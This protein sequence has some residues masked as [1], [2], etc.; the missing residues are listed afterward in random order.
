[1][2]TDVGQGEEDRQ[3][4]VP[5]VLNLPWILLEVRLADRRCGRSKNIDLQQVLLCLALDVLLLH[6]TTKDI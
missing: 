3:G 4:V 5:H 6:Q 1:M 2:S